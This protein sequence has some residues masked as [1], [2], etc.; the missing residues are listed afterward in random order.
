V[1]RCLNQFKAVI[2]DMDGLL[3]DTETIAIESFQ[4]ACEENGFKPDLQVY[5]RCIGT[6]HA[7]TRKI[8]EEGYGDSFQYDTIAGSWNRIFTGRIENDKIALKTGAVELLNYL[9]SSGI[10]R[11][12]VTSTRH[13]TACKMLSNAGLRDYFEFIIGG[14]EIEHGKP[15]PDIYLKAC[16]QTGLEPADCLALEDSENGV[17]SAV[18]AGLTVI[19]VPDIVKPSDEVKAL[20]HM[21]MPSLADVEAY[22]R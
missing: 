11:A 17:R 22:L 19:Q 6:T 3:L 1:S 9:V 13:S 8:L 14:D 18:A 4:A 7:M 5:Y 12:V 21:I 2:F 15:A 16:R 20:G 10:R